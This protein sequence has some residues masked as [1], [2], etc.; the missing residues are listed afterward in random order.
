MKEGKKEIHVY[1]KYFITKRNQ[2]GS[3]DNQFTETVW[4]LDVDK[5][6]LFRMRVQSP[7][8]NFKIALTTADGAVLADA[9]SVVGYGASISSVISKD[10]LNP[11]NSKVQIKFHFYDFLKTPEEIIEHEDVHDCH[12]PHIVL[13]MSI[14]EKEEFKAR[15]D[16]Y[17]QNLPSNAEVRFPAIEQSQ[18]GYSGDNEQSAKMSNSDNYYDLTKT[19]SD[20]KGKFQ[21]LKEYHFTIDSEDERQKNK[22]A[23]QLLYYLQLQLTADFMTSGSMHVV[24]VHEK[25]ESDPMVQKENLFAYDTLNCA[26]EMVCVVSHRTAKNEESLHIALTEGSYGI[27]FVD[28]QNEG[29]RNYIADTVKKI[30]FSSVIYLYPVEAQDNSVYCDGLSIPDPYFVPYVITEKAIFDQK[31]EVNLRNAT[32]DLYFNIDTEEITY[33]RVT[34]EQDIGMDVDI[35][36]FDSS[37]TELA[38]GKDIGATETAVAKVPIKGRIKVQLSYRNS[39]IR[40]LTSCPQVHLYLR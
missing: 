31:I 39:I 12:L 4:D 35:K 40:D 5:D 19:D 3:E 23:A 27:Y 13:E 33:V 14:M 24:V 8:T 6:L 30:P 22:E 34:T 9:P 15:K 11:G 38:R 25:D 10:K 2:G 28:Y 32:Q 18:I 7:N 37:N 26:E 17:T 20:S 29:M 1:R 16:K 21:I 36:I